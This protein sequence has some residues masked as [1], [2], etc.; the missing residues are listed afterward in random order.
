MPLVA[1]C[2]VAH[3]FQKCSVPMLCPGIV[4]YLAMPQQAIRPATTNKRAFTSSLDGED[5]PLIGQ[6]LAWRCTRFLFVFTS[7]GF[8]VSYKNG[9]KSL[10][11]FQA[12]V[13]TTYRA[14]SLTT[15]SRSLG[16][17]SSYSLWNIKRCDTTTRQLSG[18]YFSTYLTRLIGAVTNEEGL[19]S[20]MTCH[21]V[22]TR[23]VLG[24]GAHIQICNTTHSFGHVNIWS[25]D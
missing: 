3:S 19:V 12:R 17:P 11:R 1:S 5:I 25:P 7:I 23:W 14:E 13:T 18:M 8:Q 16:N 2:V 10:L 21:K 6:I 22:D 15:N 20:F 9:G 4:S 24:G